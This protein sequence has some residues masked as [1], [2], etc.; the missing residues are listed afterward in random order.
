[1]YYRTVPKGYRMFRHPK[2]AM[3]FYI[4][5]LAKFTLDKFT[6]R[7]VFLDHAK[8]SGSAVG[9]SFLSNEMF[10]AEIKKKIKS[11]EPFFVADMETASLLRVFML[12]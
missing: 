1:M 7:N 4:E 12:Y 9:R 10:N 2:I 5:N 6:K 11:G 3:Q 8:K